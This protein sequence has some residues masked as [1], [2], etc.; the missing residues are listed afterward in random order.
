MK[1]KETKY[2]AKQRAWSA[3][4]M[5]LSMVLLSITIH[6]F[7]TKNPETSERKDTMYVDYPL[8]P[9]VQSFYSY[10]EQDEIEVPK[11]ELT[12]VTMNYHLPNRVLGV[13]WGMFRDE[14]VVVNING[15]IWQYLSHEQKVALVF[16]ELLHDVYDVEHL[17]IDGLMDPVLKNGL[18]QE[19]LAEWIEAYVKY[20]KENR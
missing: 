6:Q 20:I 11:V 18:T 17:D 10:L 8:L 1:K 7:Y 2:S 3:I 15:R 9:Y 5:G 13:A 19:E 16:H 12:T 4:S 14:A